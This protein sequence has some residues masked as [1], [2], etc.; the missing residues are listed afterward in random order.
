[1]RL[2][3][4]SSLAIVAAVSLGDIGLAADKKPKSDKPISSVM[5]CLR[6]SSAMLAVARHGGGAPGAPENSI[7]A[8]EQTLPYAA[9]MQIDVSGSAEGTL[10]LMRDSTLE[11]TT[12]GAGKTAETYWPDLQALRLRDPGGV[13]TSLPIPTLADALDWSTGK[14]VLMIDKQLGATWAEIIAMV[15]QHGAEDRVI[16]TVRSPVEV[17]EIRRLSDR[18]GVRFDLRSAADSDRLRDLDVKSNSLLG[19]SAAADSALWKTA[20]KKVAIGFS[21]AGEPGKSADEKIVADGNYS[22]YEWFAQSGV[23]FLLTDNPQAVSTLKDAAK[24]RKACLNR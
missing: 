8:M 23:D 22:E 19:W 3:V 5:S 12:T 13:E 11:R 7:V 4:I 2:S 20:K 1:M 15:K 24:G 18:L 6:G 9:V 21:T 17:A 16:A 10:F 14:A